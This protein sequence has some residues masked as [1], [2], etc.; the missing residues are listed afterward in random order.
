MPLSVGFRRLGFP[1]RPALRCPDFPRTRAL[2]VTRPARSIVAAVTF[3]NVQTGYNAAMRWF[4]TLVASALALLGVLDASGASE[5]GRPI[6]QAD[7]GK[8]F[9][10]KRGGTMSLRLSNRWVWSTPRASTKGVELTPVEY[11][12]D[13]GFREWLI[14]GRTRGTLSIRAYG[15]PNCTNCTRAARQF[16][17]TITVNSP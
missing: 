10:V 16:R 12:I 2:A 11:L 6:T 14:H 15:K 13:P 4:A 7:S 1:Q 5:A 17:V 3:W 8:A 9:R